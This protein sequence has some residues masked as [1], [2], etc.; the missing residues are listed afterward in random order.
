MDN[1]NLVMSLLNASNIGSIPQIDEFVKTYIEKLI[2]DITT[3]VNSDI[4]MLPIKY[5]EDYMISTELSQEIIGVPGAYCAVDASVPALV[6]FAEDYAKLGIT[7]Y[8]QLAREA[9]MDFMN[10]HNGLFVV[11]LSKLNLCELS[12]DVPKNIEMNHH[13]T[14]AEYKT[15]FE[16]PIQFK[17]GVIKFLLCEK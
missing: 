5:Y 7:S 16:I 12:L 1:K 14:T 3:Y 2:L 6:Q 9:I 10:L 17:Y 4:S 13:I 15:I 11:L 8:G